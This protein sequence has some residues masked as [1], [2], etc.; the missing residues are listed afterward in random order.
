MRKGID[1]GSGASNCFD[2]EQNVS[3]VLVPSAQDNLGK[4]GLIGQPVFL[5]DPCQAG[6]TPLKTATIRQNPGDIGSTVNT[7]F[8]FTA[9]LVYLTNNSG[10]MNR[11]GSGNSVEGGMSSGAA[12]VTP[13]S[14]MLSPI[15]TVPGTYSNM[16]SIGT[17]QLNVTSGLNASQTTIVDLHELVTSVSINMTT[18]AGTA[19]L[20]ISASPDN[21]NYLTVDSI[22]AAAA[23]A[24][25][26]GSTTAGASTAIAP[27]SYRYLKIVAG[28]A[29]VGNTTT[30]NIGAK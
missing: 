5:I 14:H 10:Q 3:S 30:Q 7:S 6:D 20:T 27:L 17:A 4:L 26:Y 22:A 24:K 23:T 11:L 8:L 25:I 1:F 13:N 18:S 19:T 15:S 12:L 2:F 28:A 16:V 9:G 29:G 21:T